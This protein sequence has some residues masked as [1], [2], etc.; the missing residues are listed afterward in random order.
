MITEWEHNHRDNAIIWKEGEEGEKKFP[1]KVLYQF[2]NE[3]PQIE[4]ALVDEYIKLLKQQAAEY[5][6]NLSY[7]HAKQ[8][9][10]P[11]TIAKA[12][13]IQ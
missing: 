11:K 6:K 3:N 2:Q 7:E 13:T 1:L 4:R 9:W 5:S 8:L 10:H 12:E